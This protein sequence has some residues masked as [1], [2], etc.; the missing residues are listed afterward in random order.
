MEEKNEKINMEKAEKALEK[1]QKRYK[2]QNDYIE[3]TFDRVSVTLPKGTKTRI[4]KN[5]SG[6]SVNAF[7]KYAILKA[8]EDN[9]L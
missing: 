9:N 2:R 3:K 5:N 4:Q 7:I 6:L 8:L 1:L